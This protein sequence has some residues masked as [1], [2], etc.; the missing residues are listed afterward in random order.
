MKDT[1]F[2]DIE[3]QFVLH[4]RHITSPLQ[5][6]ASKS[7]VRFEVFAAVNMK[8]SVYWDATSSGSR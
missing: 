5:T 8:N 3:T 7:Y 6:P 1:V 4:R 2:W